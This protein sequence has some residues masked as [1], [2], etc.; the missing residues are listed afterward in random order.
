MGDRANYAILGE[1]SY[2]LFYSRFGAVTL[3]QDLAGGPAA[4]FDFVR[5]QEP[6][7]HW[8]DDI[9]C[10][11]AAL[12]DTV[13]KILLY[14][15]WHHDGVADRA[16]RLADI[17]NAWPGWTARWAFGGVEDVV[18]HLGIDRQLVRTQRES[19]ESVSGPVEEYPQ[20]ATCV[21]TIRGID[22]E[23]RG[24]S[25]YHEFC[26]PLWVGPKLLDLVASLAP[27]PGRGVL[28][29][30]DTGP[31]L[32]VHLDVAKRE[33]GFWTAATFMGTLDDLAARWPGWRLEFWADR[34]AEQTQRCGPDFQM[35]PF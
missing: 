24:Y 17:E 14:F 1:G 7:E 31:D 26:E 18:A 4:V 21:L 8:L 22:G 23:L 3:L 16:R 19:I 12:I 13:N 11:G 15:S 32:G 34:H 20:D 28:S 5:N 30:D 35:F 29:H 9:W 27:V 33:V 10:E 2:Q 25:V 6:A